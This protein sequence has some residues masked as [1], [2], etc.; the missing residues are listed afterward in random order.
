LRIQASGSAGVCA[1]FGF[2]GFKASF[3]VGSK[4][5]FHRG[6]TEFAQAVA[7]KVQ[8]TLGLFAEV[9]VLGAGGLGQ[10]RGDELEALRAIFPSDVLVM[11]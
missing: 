8:L 4:P 10:H 7:W 2:K 5:V 6:D 3:A 1:V 9:L 11:F